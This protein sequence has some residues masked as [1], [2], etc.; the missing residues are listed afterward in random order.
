MSFLNKSKVYEEKPYLSTI[1]CDIHY[2]EFTEPDCTVDPHYHTVI[3]IIYELNGP[4]EV[5]VGQRKYLLNAGDMIFINSKEPHATRSISNEFSKSIVLK[6]P[7]E[8]IC[9]EQRSIMELK[10]ILPSLL[11][12][13]KS[14]VL[15]TKDE[16]S[17]TEVE[18]AINTIMREESEKEYAFNFAISIYVSLM[19]LAVLRYNQAIFHIESAVPKKTEK[20]FPTIFRYINEHYA[21][22]ITAKQISQ[23]FLLRQSDFSSSF[24][25]LT[26]KTFKEYLNYIRLRKAKRLLIE[27]NKSITEI[28]YETG[29]ANTS[30]FIKQFKNHTGNTPLGFKKNFGVTS[31]KK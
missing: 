13:E 7:P 31:S 3:E 21:E 15:F 20:A 9:N 4:L 1:E 27:T 10:Y 16:I 5:T 25:T 2:Q 14:K 6:F 18:R 22:N 30:Y 17:G 8:M 12:H 24:I 28:S 26:G 29:F 23:E 11:S 19:Y